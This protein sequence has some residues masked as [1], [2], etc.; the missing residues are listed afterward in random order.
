MRILIIAGKQ[1]HKLADLAKERFGETIDID[2]INTLDGIEDYVN[3]GNDF[4][5]VIIFPKGYSADD[6]ITDIND[7]KHN[8]TGFI[9]YVNSRIYSYELVI[10]SATEEDALGFVEITLEMN[11]KT[12]IIKNETSRIVKSDLYN[13]V[14][15]PII[16]L[17]E[18]YRTYTLSD[19][20]SSVAESTDNNIPVDSTFD[21]DPFMETSTGEH[22][23]G[24]WGDDDWG[25]SAD[26]KE[27]EIDMSAFDTPDNKQEEVD[28]DPFSNS[29]DVDS[30]KDIGDDTWDTS[31]L[32]TYGSE[33]ATQLGDDDPFGADAEPFGDNKDD[34]VGDNPFGEATNGSKVDDNTFGADAEPFGENKVD[35]NPF[36]DTNTNGE[37]DT[38]SGFSDDFGAVTDNKEFNSSD[39][40]TTESDTEDP[41]KDNT[42]SD[43]SDTKLPD[44]S[45]FDIGTTSNNGQ[46][47]VGGVSELG[48]SDFDDFGGKDSGNYSTENFGDPFEEKPVAQ[49]KAPDPFEDD[50]NDVSEIKNKSAN[51]RTSEKTDVRSLFDEE[52][53]ETPVVNNKAGLSNTDMN[54]LFDDDSNDDDASDMTVDEPVEE[55]APVKG[56]KGKQKQQP[57]QNNNIGVSGDKVA[58]LKEKL[59]VFK[60]TGCIITVTGGIG[61]GKTTVSANIANLLCKMGYSVL[62][63]DMDT[64]GR[65]HSSIN[66]ENYEV[67]NSGEVETSNV[68]Q[69][70]GSTGDRTG[71]YVSIVREGYHVLGTGLKVDKARAEDCLSNKYIN[72]FLHSC[73]NTYNFVIIDIPFDAVV[74]GFSDV[75][76]IA[77]YVVL[78]ERMNNYGLMNMITDMTN[79]DDE[80]LT[81]ELFNKSKLL[82]NME[83]HCT[84]VLGKKVSGTKQVLN[85]L[86]LRMSEILGYRID[87]S[88]AEMDVLGVLSY[89]V[90]ID[91]CW[92]TKKYYTDTTEGK[93]LFTNLLCGIFE[94]K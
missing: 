6:T 39:F 31:K 93:N 33:E 4:E 78:T 11:D 2:S 62:V 66:Y 49:E 61:S 7:V 73:Q 38:G 37:F 87:D 28:A 45:D 71:R 24:D 74:N 82:F 50:F 16:K 91:R 52:P 79:S 29:T 44:A 86:D 43:N 40:D 83:D 54:S 26:N 69:A 57:R 34:K 22:G 17:K 3:R 27:P 60:R 20:K 68:M 13:L 70:L 59:S 42:K 8:M 64:S 84:S 10:M 15:L 32:G 92:F 19:L 23:A 88:F 65:G 35:D 30:L 9:S 51:S 77:N 21:D 14:S 46:F 72:R 63:V 12:T 75:I 94:V 5:R 56:K 85:A 53:V 48:D 90:N 76:T 81:Y 67:I 47:N 41:F 89:N 80:D 58:K 18:K 25:S 55:T 1:A 36:G